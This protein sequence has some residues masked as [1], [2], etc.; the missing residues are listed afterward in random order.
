MVVYGLWAMDIDLGQWNGI[1]V[2]I[3]GLLW[4]RERLAE[5]ADGSHFVA[6]PWPVVPSYK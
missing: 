6:G 2:Y 3:N 1:K 4:K 5:G